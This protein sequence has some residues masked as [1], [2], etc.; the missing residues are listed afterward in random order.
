MGRHISQVK[1]LRQGTWPPSV[2]AFVQSLNA[3]GGAN[4]V[5]E[6]CL[7]ESITVAKGANRRQKPSAKDVLHPTKAEF[8]RAKHVSLA[9]VL[10]PSVQQ[11]E[12]GGGGGFNVANSLEIELSRQLR[13]SV[14]S[15]NLETSLRLLVQGADPNYYY[16]EKGSMPLHVAAKSGQAAQIEL[17]LV[18]GANL[19]AKDGNGQTAVDIAKVNKH[20]TI[21]ER[22]VEA[23][24][25][26]TDR[27]TVFLGGRQPDHGAGN[28][29]NAV[30]HDA[31]SISSNE[32]SEQLKIARGKLQLIP[33]KMF[34]ELVMD[35]Y[36][37]VDRREME[38]SMLA[39]KK[40]IIL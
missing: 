12:D 37:E 29:F 5:W 21:A 1:S 14:R 4:S 18:Y 9:F 15:P 33:N 30:T 31:A 26:V 2:F 35:V 39:A 36:D 23:A 19:A 22:L 24:Y 6:H 10:K 32:I 20:F 25:E 38:A 8:I 7:L 40:C 17:L 27:L 3:H 28:H 34:E 11:L 13:A 16:D